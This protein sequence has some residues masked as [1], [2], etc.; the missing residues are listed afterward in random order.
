M[1]KFIP[2]IG[3][4]FLALIFLI[5]GFGKIADFNGTQQYMVSQGMPMTGLLLVLAIIFELGGGLSIITGFKARWGAGALIVFLVLATAV[6]HMDLA[7]RMQMTQFL[8][9]LSMI[10]GLLL[11]VG[12]GSGPYSLDNKSK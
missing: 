7:D 3:R 11:V 2:L 5:S 10:G 9:N 12:F 1:Q 8:K 4:I 6:F